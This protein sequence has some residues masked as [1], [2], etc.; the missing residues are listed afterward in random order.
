M[1]ENHQYQPVSYNKNQLEQVK[2]NMNNMA[3]FKH[4]NNTGNTGYGFEQVLLD[5]DNHKFLY[6]KNGNAVKRPINQG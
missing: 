4:R 3:A 1:M 6:Q 2:S 5:D